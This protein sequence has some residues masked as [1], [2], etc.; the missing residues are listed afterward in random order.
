MV[1]K[2]KLKFRYQL[3]QGLGAIGRWSP[4]L[5]ELTNNTGIFSLGYEPTYEEL[6]QASRGKKS[7][8]DPS[9]M[10]IPYIRTTFPALVMVIMPKPFKESEDEEPDLDC[11]IQLCLKEFST[12]ATTSLEDNP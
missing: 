1:A 9:R 12:N 6:F 3:G 11:I 7:K 5:I 4:T 2:E 8:C 10:S